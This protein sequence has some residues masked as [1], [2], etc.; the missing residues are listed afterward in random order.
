MHG[1][2][3]KLKRHVSVRHE[4]DGRDTEN[5]F[6]GFLKF[7]VLCTHVGDPGAV[8]EIPNLFYIFLKRRHEGLCHIN[9][10]FFHRSSSPLFSDA[11]NGVHDINKALRSDQGSGARIYTYAEKRLHQKL[12]EVITDKAAGT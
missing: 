12:Y 7:R 11:T 3:A 9:L 8:P 2:K 1:S 6:Q 5:A 4:R 10:F